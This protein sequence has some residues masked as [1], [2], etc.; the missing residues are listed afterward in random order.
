[1]KLATKFIVSTSTVLLVIF[2][3]SIFVN[4]QMAERALEDT[5]YEAGRVIGEMTAK[6]VE[7]AEID[8]RNKAEYVGLFLASIAPQLLT[9]LDLVTLQRLSAL[10]IND[11]DIK[12]A[13]ILNAQ[14]QSMVTS[15][16]RPSPNF[17]VTLPMKAGD[18][19]LG[20]IRIGYTMERTDQHLAETQTTNGERY[21][22]IVAANQNALGFL[23]SVNL[24]TSLSAALLIAI[25]CTLLLRQYVHRPLDRIVAVAEQLAEGDLRAR[26]GHTSKDEMGILAQAFNRMSERFSELITQVLNS[27]KQLASTSTEVVAITEKAQSGVHTQHRE[28]ELV[29]AAIQEMT[30]TVTNVSSGATEAS[31]FARHITTEAEKGKHVVD[32][33]VDMIHDVSEHVDHSTT[34]VQLLGT[35]SQSIGTIVDVIKSIAD[36]TNLLALNASIEAARAGEQGRGFAVVADEVRI[37][38]RRTQQSTAEIESMIAK[39]QEDARQAVEAM[40]GS[41]AQVNRSVDQARIA[42]N[43]LEM[44]LNEIRGISAVN[45]HIASSSEEQLTVVEELNRNMIAIGNVADEAAQGINHTVKATSELEQTAQTLS[46]LVER[47][48]V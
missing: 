18:I 15:G 31:E 12:Y 35:H 46:T 8:V 20:S 36:Q 2:S 25:S 41:Q 29:A 24:F 44:I 28:V 42:G 19:N 14:G 38:A 43:S 47:F 21:D 4:H 7:I 27:S 23:A 33:T 11:R 6:Q 34:A 5:L 45:D 13:E 32:L 39:L 17:L 48:K 37:L 10:A 9:D 26:V 16:T 40:E 1:M 22:A 3:G 30:A